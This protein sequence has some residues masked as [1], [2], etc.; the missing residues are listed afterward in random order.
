[1]KQ[2]IIFSILAIGLGTM[3]AC[4]VP[5]DTTVN[6][7]LPLP[8]SFN[9]DTDTVN[10]AGLTRK[11]FYTSPLLDALLDTVIANNY[12]LLIA[13]QRIEAARAMVLQ[14]R[15]LLAPQV[16][17]GVV[18]S[19]RK[20]GLYTMDGAGNKTTDIEPG[21]VVPENLP[22]FYMGLQ[23]SWEVD[24]WGKL[25]NKK[26]AALARVLASVEG[27]HYIQTSLVAETAGAYYELMAADQVLRML[28][29][30]ILLQE[31]AIGTVRILKENAKVNELAVQQFEAQLLGMK[32]MRLETQQLVVAIEN[33][34]NFLA[35]RLPRPVVRDS[36]FFA[37]PSLPLIKA[38]I[39]TA[40]LRNR[41]DIRQ[42][43]WELAATKADLRSA[44]AAYFPSFTLNAGIGLQAYRASLL[45]TFPESVA[46]SLIAGLAGPVLNRRQIEAEFARSSAQQKEALYKYQQTVTRSFLEV[47]QELKKILNLDQVFTLKAK[48]KDILSSSI[49]VSGDLFRTGRANYLEVLITRQNALRSNMELINTR[50]NQ[51]LAV[52]SLYKAIGGGW[53]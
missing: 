10:S 17:A 51:Y 24:I 35:G 39:P 32:T 43:E 47:D 12:D 22:D 33:Q 42:A 13:A 40:L 53:N 48:E 26:K 37:N 44:R 5:A 16:N 34:I 50:K 45:F 36:S 9:Q 29:E 46:Y 15:G 41:P 49:T 23:T 7:Q 19:L 38:G 1:M 18:P 6:H 8:V 30:T 27:K 20:F 3:P 21:K 52:I 14:T 25:K 31:Q 2:L 4:R 11:L 28:D